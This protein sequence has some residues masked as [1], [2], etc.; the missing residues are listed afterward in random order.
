ME[1]IYIAIGCWVFELRFKAHFDDF[2]EKPK[3]CIYINDLGGV[4]GATLQRYED[5]IFCKV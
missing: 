1:A 5:V 4:V 2:L 3:K